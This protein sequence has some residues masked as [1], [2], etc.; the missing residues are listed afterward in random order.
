M[1]E[2]TKPEEKTG[3][4]QG[5]GWK[6][7][8]EEID[9][10]SKSLKRVGVLRRDMAHSSF[11]VRKFKVLGRYEIHFGQAEGSFSTRSRTWKPSPRWT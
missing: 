3:G 5:E 6:V 4:I 8:D 1:D 7:T 2:N 10:L 11:Q 9:R